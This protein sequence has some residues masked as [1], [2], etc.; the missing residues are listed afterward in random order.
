MKNSTTAL[1]TERRSK[2][3][4]GVYFAFL[5]L[6]CI[7]PLLVLAAFKFQCEHLFA[8]KNAG[9]Q[10]LI[11]HRDTNLLLIG[12]SHTRQGYDVRKL[13]EEIGV[14]GF[15]IAYNGLD[16][17][18]MDQVISYLAERNLCP[19]HVVV[20]GYSAFLAKEPD[21]E[22]PRMFFDAPPPLK[23]TFVVTYIA[24]HARPA[25]YLDMI[26]LSVSRGSESLLTYPVNSKVLSGLSYHGGSETIFPG[27][28][29]AAFADFRVTEPFSGTV[30]S[31]QLAAV[32]HIIDITSTHGIEI[33]F[34]DPPMPAPVVADHRIHELKAD[35][36][37]LA[38]RRKITYVDGNLD[39]P[40][41]DPALFADNNH[42]SGAG[43]DLFTHLVAVKLGGWISQQTR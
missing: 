34:I 14:P 40:D 12:S 33:M 43:R 42:L 37:E 4:P 16:F 6:F 8:P 2:L 29:H 15:S 41:G 31:H 38:A 19:K 39:F 13:E 17:V 28:S 27:V 10:G 11:A 3:S 30:N 20:E 5:M 7:A 21:L 22:D 25:A 32:N 9:I 1:L 23:R 26:D 18:G 36:R 24:E 35:L